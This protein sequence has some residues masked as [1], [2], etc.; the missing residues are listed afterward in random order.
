M[1]TGFLQRLWSVECPSLKI[2]KS[3]LDVVLGSQI[4][5]TLFKGKRAGPDHLQEPRPNSPGFPPNNPRSTSGQI[6][7]TAEAIKAHLLALA[8]VQ[9]RGAHT[10]SDHQLISS[11]TFLPLPARFGMGS[12]HHSLPACRPWGW[13]I[14]LLSHASETRELQAGA[15]QVPPGEVQGSSALP[16]LISES[17]PSHT[18][19]GENYQP[20]RQHE[21]KLR[22]N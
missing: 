12:S 17:S 7:I 6:E 21:L 16:S 14:T 3:Q 20:C 13:G 11:C 19:R 22:L 8:L 5:V 4:C 15:G 2:L 1:G 18:G 9:P 10:I